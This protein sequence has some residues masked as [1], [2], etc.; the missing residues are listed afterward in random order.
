MASNLKGRYP[1]A[2]VITGAS[3]G[4]GEA[5]A[6]RLAAE[7]IDL[8]LVARR[9][10]RL[11]RLCE[12]LSRAHNVKTLPVGLDLTTEDCSTIL[13][14]TLDDHG[15]EVGILI[16]NAGYGSHGAFHEL[17]PVN[18]VRMVELNC[19]APVAITSA[20]LPGMVQRRSGAIVFVAS[21]AGFQPT[22]FLST[23]GA[24]KAFDLV[25]AEALWA[26]L[27]PLGIDVIALCPGYTPTEFQQRAN[28]RMRAMGPAQQPAEVVEACIQRLGR[29]PS[30]VSGWLNYLMTFGVRFAPRGFVARMAARASKPTYIPRP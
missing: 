21:V 3:S 16:N 1:G 10:D 2:A 19:R 17:D 13:K 7:G 28:L 15:T 8:V 24:T 27:R 22:P 5:F 12:E 25:F 30:V 6:R 23:Y 18:E 29:G 26:E 11:D 4:I 14:S 9:R 20:F